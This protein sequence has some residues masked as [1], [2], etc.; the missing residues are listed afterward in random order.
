MRGTSLKERHRYNTTFH[1]AKLQAEVS[2]CMLG[3]N[4][5]H[6]QINATRVHLAK[7]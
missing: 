7:K 3:N 5:K 4:A 6:I 2:T 1:A